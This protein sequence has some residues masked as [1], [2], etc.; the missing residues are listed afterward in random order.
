MLLT[1]HA[2][3]HH[4]RCTKAPQPRCRPRCHGVAGPPASFSVADATAVDC[5]ALAAAHPLLAPLIAEGVITALRRPTGVPERRSDGYREPGIVVLI[6]VAHLSTRSPADVRHVIGV[7]KPQCVVVEL[8]RSRQQQLYDGGG[9]EKSS[10]FALTGD[11]GAAQGLLPALQRALRLGGGGALLLRAAMAAVANK[12]AGNGSPPRP[13]AGVPAFGSEFTAARQAAEEVGAQVVLGDRPLEI[14]LQRAIAATSWADR[15]QGLGLVT[16]TLSGSTETRGGL[17]T[18]S[19]M[20]ALVADG[21]AVDALLSGFTTAFPKL[22]T[23]LVHER[24]AYLAWSLCRSKAVDGTDVVVGVVG[25][26][27]VRGIVWAMQPQRREELRFD[28][29]TGRGLAEKQQRPLWQRLAVDVALWGVLPW[30]LWRLYS[31]HGSI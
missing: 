9:S 31:S 22:A 10:P 3:T 6:G 17:V 14:T 25:K 19:A 20:D 18:A 28:T 2:R 12:A 27:H 30:A 13:G 26:A 23:A 5:A 24:D 8:C 7:L 16:A 29:L 1:L 11:G 21:Q 15:A 4:G